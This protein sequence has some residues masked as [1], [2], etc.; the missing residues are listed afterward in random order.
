MIIKLHS[1]YGTILHNDQNIIVYDESM[2]FDIDSEG[3]KNLYAVV[4]V[5]GKKYTYR[6]IDNKITVPFVNLADG[7]MKI[8]IQQVI[9]GNVCRRWSV[10]TIHLKELENN[11]TVITEFE[12]INEELTLIK[13]ALVELKQIVEKYNLI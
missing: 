8:T 3:H 12:R 5:G 13:S 1:N 10:E 9:N 6:V 11:Y 7:E 2:T 4:V